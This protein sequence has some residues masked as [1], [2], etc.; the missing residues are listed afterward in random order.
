M[1]EGLGFSFLEPS[2][3]FPPTAARAGSTSMRPRLSGTPRRVCSDSEALWSRVLRTTARRSEGN[4][5]N[6]GNDDEADDL[7]L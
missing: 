2:H 7:M 3:N 5:G 1:F 4:D 6:D